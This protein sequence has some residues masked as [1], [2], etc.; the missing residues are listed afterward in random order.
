[1]PEESGLGA[2]DSVLG[3]DPTL[4]R[5][6]ITP[7]PGRQVPPA[8]P[9]T[10]GT[11]MQQVLGTPEV[12]EPKKPDQGFLSRAYSSLYNLPSSLFTAI[13]EDA[14]GLGLH[15][16]GTAKPDTSRV[17]EIYS[18]GAEGTKQGVRD[19]AYSRPVLGALSLVA[20]E[21]AAKARES[22]DAQRK[23]FETKYGDSNW[24]TLGRLGG[25]FA[26]T[27]GPIGAAGKVASLGARYIPGAV[28][29]LA[30]FATGVNQAQG[31]VPR[32]AQLATEGAIQGGEYGALTSGQ[33]D[34]SLGQQIKE[35]ALGGA[36]GSV[37]LGGAA[38]LAGKV[39]GLTRAGDEVRAGL[40]KQAMDELGVVLPVNK[41]PKTPTSGTQMADIATRRQVQK[42][43]LADMGENSNVASPE[44]MLAAKQR[45]NM[46]YENLAKRVG[47][48]DA[49]GMGTGSIQGEMT[50]IAKELADAGLDREAKTAV[51]R[52]MQDVVER[53]YGPSGGGSGRL[54][55]DGF[56]DL[57]SSNGRLAK[58]IENARPEVRGFL[59]QV[60]D[61]VMA[62]LPASAGPADAEA[63]KA[64][65]RQW[66]VM[67][68]VEDA[69]LPTGDISFNKLASSIEK[70]GK[71]LDPMSQQYAY[72][73]QG[74]MNLFAR[75]GREFLGTVP[76]STTAERLTAGSL[77]KM[78]VDAVTRA[79]RSAYRSVADSDWARRNQI[80]ALT[81]TPVSRWF[82][83]AIPD[84][85]TVVRP[86][87]I[88]G[89]DIREEARRRPQ[90]GILY[91]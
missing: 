29:R 52:Q 78:A 50:R 12:T 73:N 1:M 77:S 90:G 2:L 16:P 39:S 81:G 41:P 24:A 69:V 71:Q 20:P 32:A 87:A 75:I 13:K 55:T 68:T 48:V 91:Q 80:E 15:V 82:S 56:L 11:P 21:T 7:G 83:H 57:T 47:F 60:H 26:A 45:L 28:G 35:G 89:A 3:I 8:D 70:R 63:A 51:Q 54:A 65:A 25:Q 5:T 43:L 62:R 38:G 14:S 19:V 4:K 59:Q 37:A 79:G 33:S 30:E 34:E 23:D 40:A 76:D 31:F 10:L 6:G 84:S 36:V 42:Q 18:P 9:A 49:G 85:G 86:G 67:R 53:F 22:A 74:R 66:R 46:G 64:L 27:S 58:A 44:V 17:G 61:A 88:L 72:D